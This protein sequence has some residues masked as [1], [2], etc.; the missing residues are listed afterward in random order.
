MAELYWQ[1][2]GSGSPLVMI[3]GWAMHSGI[4][5]DFAKQLGQ[6][7]QVHCVDLPGHG[8]SDAIT[9]FNLEQITEQL[10]ANCELASA[11]WLGWSMGANVAMAMAKQYPERVDALVVIAGNPC[12][13]AKPDWPGINA[14][15]L[16]LFA[17]NL[18]KDYQQTLHRF[19]ALQTRG[20]ANAKTLLMQLELTVNECDTPDIV[21]LQEGL[22]ILKSVDQRADLAKIICPALVVL[23][24]QDTL[25]P[26]KVFK[27]ISA[28]VPN[29]QVQVL[30]R[31]GHLSFLSEPALLDQRISDFLLQKQR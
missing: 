13:S 29:W 22:E 30:E 5:R 11:S 6:S 26:A 9:P 7:F 12:F 1:R 15:A 14:K 28:L 24:A 27:E 18:S 20:I 21:T 25:V 8:R 17:D 16:G 10:A 3:H 31:V 23:G 2:F 19:L 4:W